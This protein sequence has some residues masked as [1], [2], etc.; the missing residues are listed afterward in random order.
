MATQS[1]TY[2]PPQNDA[3]KNVAGNA[4]DRD[5]TTCMRAAVIGSSSSYVYN[6][7]WWRVD[8]GGVYSIYSVK[9]L[10]KNYGGYGIFLPFGLKRFIKE[11]MYIGRLFKDSKWFIDN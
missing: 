4:V 8:L 9:I 11:R 6:T 10:F 7:V 5:I 1:T 2:P 3:D